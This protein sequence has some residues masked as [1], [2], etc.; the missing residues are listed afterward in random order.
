MIIQNLENINTNSFDYTVVGSGP[1]GI[2]L[3]LQLAQKN[4]KVLLIEAGGLYFSEN[5]QLFYKGETF[6]DKYFQLDITRL[7]YFGGSSG[8]WAGACRTLDE[9]DFQSWPISKKSLDNFEKK[10]KEILNI[11]GNFYSKQSE[12]NNFNNINLLRSD[13]QFG[14]KYK[15]KIEKS[16]N[17]FLLL[18]SP[19]LQIIPDKQNYKKVSEILIN[20]NN[21]KKKK[22]KI[23]NLVLATGGIENSR[24]LLWS[25]YLSKNNFL[26]N[27]P[28][29]NYWNEHPA[30]EIAQFV[31]ERTKD[32]PLIKKFLGSMIAPVPEFI[33]KNKINNIRLDF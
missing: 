27:L 28:I 26:K 29:G 23:N 19:L 9:V 21:L 22:I 33:N 5:S 10:A 18:N 4:K 17:I 13:V 1:A 11:K 8:H 32:D 20:I 12:F 6:G 7:R 2:T 24:I 25:R 3:S 15:S 30:G 14:E 31:S 16:N